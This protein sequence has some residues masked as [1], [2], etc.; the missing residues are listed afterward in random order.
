MAPNLNEA[1]NHSTELTRRLGPDQRLLWVDWLKGIALIWIFIDHAVE[2]VFGG[3]FLGNPSLRWP[4][5]QERIAQWMPLSGFGIWTVPVNIW[6][7]IGWLGDQGVGLFLVTSGFGLT[8]GLLLRHQDSFPTFAFYKKRFRRVYPLWWG[9]HIFF[10][11]A[12]NLTGISAL[13][14]SLHDPNFLLSFIGF[15]SSPGTFYYFAPAWWYIGLIIQL[16]LFFPVLWAGLKRLG[17]VRFLVLSCLIAFLARMLVIMIGITPS[18]FLNGAVFITRLP[19]FAF[20]MCFAYW[21]TNEPGKVQ[22][23]MCTRRAIVTAAAIYVL[24]TVLSLTWAGMVVAPLI[25]GVGIFGILFGLL[26][27][28]RKGSGVGART[29][30]WTGEHSYSL[31]LVHQPVIS[32]LA[33]ISALGGTLLSIP[34]TVLGAIGLEKLVN[35]VI[36]FADYQYK[37]YG[38]TRM[39]L[40]LA[41]AAL[42]LYVCAIGVELAVQTIAPQEVFG[43]AERSYLEPNDRFGW[44]LIPNKVTHLRFLSY[45]YYVTSNALGFPGPAYPVEKAPGTIRI[46]TFGDAFTSAEGVNT[47]QA[48]PRLLESDLAAKL[49]DHKIQVMNFAVT[50]YGPNQYAEVA[51]VFMPIYHPDMIIMG[52]FMNDYHDVSISNDAFR[53][54]IGF[55][56]PSDKGWYSTLLLS[57]S[58][59]L[60]YRTIHDLADRL[61]NRPDLGAYSVAGMLLRQPQDYEVTGPPVVSERL[62]EMKVLA[63][64][65]GTKMILFMI[66]V[67]VQVCG[68]DGISYYPKG[69]DLS[70]PSLFDLDKP[71][72]LTQEITSSLDI[73]TYDLRPALRAATTCPY[74]R[75]NLHWTALGHKAAADYISSILIEKRYLP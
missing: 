69:Y 66:P 37:K 63:D 70:D 27:N 45:D 60:L 31:Y 39:L 18:M 71:Q 73:P 49:P 38:P 74:Q 17:P 10:L 22:T 19:E 64:S 7:Y 21:L 20:G 62:G 56:S 23:F 75:Y 9:I 30:S 11:I 65:L 16:Y 72:R 43:W 48:W 61:R 54:Q 33:V 4:S 53:A 46:L 29:L 3:A 35:G 36:R 6:R 26:G 67:P 40:R 14:M 68:P 24:G 25:V 50:G 5:L 44:T 1:S 41:L 34:V 42:A 59:V 52:F 8:Y 12:F 2:A 51:K 28:I 15:R 32:L 13:Q 58:R 55:G 57:H 47:D